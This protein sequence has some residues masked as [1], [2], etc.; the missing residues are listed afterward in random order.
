MTIQEKIRTLR[1]LNHW[2]Q[3]DMAERMNLSQNGY[4]KIERGESKLSIKKL[5][6]IAQIFNI[7]ITELISRDTGFN[8]QYS[9][10]NSS[11]HYYNNASEEI[12]K[13]HLIINHKDEIITQKDNEIILLRKLLASYEEK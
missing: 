2:T 10:N 8:Y 1:Q 6:Q 12:E 7:D 11:N 4:A 9:D 3:E 5:E 13:L